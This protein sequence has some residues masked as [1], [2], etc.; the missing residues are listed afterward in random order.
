[1]DARAAPQ[2]DFDANKIRALIADYLG[3]DVERVTDEAHF[4]DDFDL[5]SL[6][7]LELLILIEEQF[8]GADLSEAAVEQIEVVGDLI[9]YMEINCLLGDLYAQTFHRTRHV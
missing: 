6:D 9:R 8:S 4:R 2:A 1:V 5:D 3:I 7:Q